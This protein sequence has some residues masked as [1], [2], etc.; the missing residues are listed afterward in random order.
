MQY[1]SN[2]I[3]A[4]FLQCADCDHEWRSHTPQR[5]P[6]CARHMG[7]TL[8]LDPFQIGVLMNAVETQCFGVNDETDLMFV[9]SE[10]MSDSWP[11]VPADMLAQACWIYLRDFAEETEKT[12]T[13][14]EYFEERFQ[15][16]L[17]DFAYASHPSPWE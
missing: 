14:M 16:S 4:Y 11:D 1:N 5:C 7:S 10:M 6:N 9:L 8:M 15:D 12:E 17:E 3:S 2:D 13:A